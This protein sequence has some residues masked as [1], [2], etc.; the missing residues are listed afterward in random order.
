L[1]M[2]ELNVPEATAAKLA[3]SILKKNL[4]VKAGETVTVEAWPHTLPWAVALA[5]EARRMKALP[6]ILYEDEAAY[7]DAVDHGEEKV[8]GS[9]AAHE[10]A[11][12]GKTDVYIHMW[13]PGDRVRLNALPPGKAGKLFGFNDKWYEAARKSGL[14]GARL[15]LG[16]PYPTLEK[17]YGADRSTWTR[18]IVEATMVDPSE[19]ARRAAPIVQALE[20]GKRLRITHPNGT[21]LTVGL[22]KRPA[23]AF[24]GRPAVN[25]PKRPFDILCNLPRGGC[26]GCRRGA[27][28]R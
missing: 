6:V 22:A 28:G 16:R 24:V 23:R 25:D 18:Q 3:Q 15:E 21:D 13:G 5:R 11:A 7:W 8:L 19:L 14:R 9:V 10:W 2:A 1:F 20:T 17:A 4:Q 27:S 26:Q 12:L